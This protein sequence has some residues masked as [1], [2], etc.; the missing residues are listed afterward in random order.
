M[1]SELCPLPFFTKLWS[2]P[3]SARDKNH[4]MHGARDASGCML[5]MT[6][7]ILSMVSEQVGAPIE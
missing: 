3:A 1:P 7:F 5:L 2:G 6:L 4:T